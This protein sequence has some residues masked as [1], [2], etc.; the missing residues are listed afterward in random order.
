MM[1]ASF[2][3]TNFDLIYHY[4]L[5][6]NVL[7]VKLHV[8]ASIDSVLLDNKQFLL[9]KYAHH[10]WLVNL[11]ICPNPTHVGIVW[12]ERNSNHIVVIYYEDTFKWQFSN[13]LHII[14]LQ[15]TQVWKNWV[16]F[17]SPLRLCEWSRCKKFILIYWI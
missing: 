7:T 16:V 1:W 5:T 8:D 6:V 4:C 15:I 17:F 12:N 13:I 14:Q 2:H 11:R 10:S 3:A 9:S